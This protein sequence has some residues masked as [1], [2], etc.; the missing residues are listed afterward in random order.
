MLHSLLKY[1]EKRQSLCANHC[2]LQLGGFVM[3]TVP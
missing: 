3:C 2:A 1:F